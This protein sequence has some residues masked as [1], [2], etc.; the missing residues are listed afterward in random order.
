MKKKW[1]QIKKH[2]EVGYRIAQTAPDLMHISEFITVT[3]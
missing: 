3:S 2:P 1:E